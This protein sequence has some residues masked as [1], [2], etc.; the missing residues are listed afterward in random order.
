MLCHQLATL[1]PQ[2]PPESAMEAALAALPSAGSMVE[3]LPAYGAVPIT[4]LRLQAEVVKGFGRGA[5]QLGFPTAN[6]DR[7]SI[8]DI[9]HVSP[10][11]YFG[12]AMVDNEGPFKAVSSVGLNPFFGLEEKTVEPHLLHEFDDD[13]YGADMK[14]VLC[15]FLRPEW[16]FP[17]LEALITAIK[18]D[19]SVASTAMDDRA[20]CFREFHSDTALGSR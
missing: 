11:V 9:D 6:M 20:K 5:K 18:N 10:G 7:K 16:N 13:F 1:A 12:W 19:C 8:G 4:P 14:L 17:S 2:L 15:G 3:Q